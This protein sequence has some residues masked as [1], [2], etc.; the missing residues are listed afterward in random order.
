MTD[1]KDFERRPVHHWYIPRRHAGF[2]EAK[3]RGMSLAEH[4][5]MGAFPMCEPGGHR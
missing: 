4:E 1:F 5:V 2:E 3:A